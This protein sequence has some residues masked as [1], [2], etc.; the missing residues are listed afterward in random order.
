MKRAILVAAA[1]TLAASVSAQ[2][3]Y[4]NLLYD[5]ENWAD[6]THLDQQLAIK[7]GVVF[8]SVDPDTGTVI[9]MHDN[10]FGLGYTGTSGERGLYVGKPGSKLTLDFLQPTEHVCFYLSTGGITHSTHMS[11]TIYDTNGSML[12]W[13]KMKIGVDTTTG[14]PTQMAVSV[15]TAGGGMV[16]GGWYDPLPHPAFFYASGSNG[17]RMEGWWMPGPF[18]YPIGHIELVTEGASK[19]GFILDDLK[20]KIAEKTFPGTG[21]D[22][23]N[24]ARV[25]NGTFTVGDT[26]PVQAGDNVTMDFWSP[27]NTYDAAAYL[28]VGQ[29][30]PPGQHPGGYDFMPGVLVNPYAD[31]APFVLFSSTVDSW[32]AGEWSVVLPDLGSGGAT[33][34]ALQGI[35]I[36][37]NAPNGLYAV[38]DMTEFVWQ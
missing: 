38:T 8:D 17:L 37:P 6:N 16:L 22:L 19:N 28:A 11:M 32:G 24:A 3:T 10:P 30:Y 18:G 35:T 4:K 34:L 2:T 1:F 25:N 7:D 27:G 12:A 15:N 26:K 31:P 20:I 29:F 33:A 9:N 5:F 36:S 14:N 21:A 13:A 23:I